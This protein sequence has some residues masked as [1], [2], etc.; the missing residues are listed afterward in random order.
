MRKIGFRPSLRLPAIR[1]RSARDSSARGGASLPISSVSDEDVE[2]AIPAAVACV[3]SDV[4]RRGRDH[5]S[6]GVHE[7]ELQRVAGLVVAFELRLVA[8]RLV[9]TRHRF[10]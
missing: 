7:L 2:L 8:L 10:G 4:N 6:G 3:V 1:A 5:A 9:S